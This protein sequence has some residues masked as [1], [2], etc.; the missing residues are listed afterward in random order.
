MAK[1]LEFKLPSM[2]PKIILLDEIQSSPEVQKAV[3]KMAENYANL[4]EQLK[5]KP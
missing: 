5:D 1:I 4:F 3:D 2:K